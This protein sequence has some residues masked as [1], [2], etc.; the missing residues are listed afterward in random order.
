MEAFQDQPQSD[1][2]GIKLE[3]IYVLNVMTMNKIP[4]TRNTLAAMKIKMDQQKRIHIYR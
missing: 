4:W 3:L 1:F 2:T